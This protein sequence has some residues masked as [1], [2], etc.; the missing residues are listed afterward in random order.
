MTSSMSRVIRSSVGRPS[1]PMAAASAA[2]PLHERPG[3]GATGGRRVLE[4][5]RVA[6]VAVERGG[7]RVELEDGFPEAVR[8]V[9][10]GRRRGIGQGHARVSCSPRRCSARSVC[11][12]RLRK[13]SAVDERL[14]SCR[15]TAASARR[16]ARSPGRARGTARGRPGR[17]DLGRG[18]CA[19][20]PT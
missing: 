4:P 3:A 19:G 17:A 1:V 5:V 13:P 9:V 16:S 7:R 12:G 8:E 14:P 15:R 20:G 10:D 6:L 2:R 11:R 18:T